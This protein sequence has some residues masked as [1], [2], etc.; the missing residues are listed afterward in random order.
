MNVRLDGTTA[1]IKVLTIAPKGLL[2]DKYLKN[3]EQR[4]FDSISSTQDVKAM[5]LDL[6]IIPVDIRL[7]QSIY[8][9]SDDR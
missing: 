6:R 2:T 7:Y 3:V 9:P 5:E 4:I 1:Y 8:S